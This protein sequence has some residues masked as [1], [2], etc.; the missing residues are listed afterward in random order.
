MLQVSGTLE[1]VPDSIQAE[2]RADINKQ[3]TETLQQYM[4]DG[5][6]DQNSCSDSESVDSQNRGECR[7][8][9]MR[10]AL[11]CSDICQGR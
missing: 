3:W 8:L 11:V 1:V 6:E 4:R 5:V 10:S 7:A 2:Q 9:S